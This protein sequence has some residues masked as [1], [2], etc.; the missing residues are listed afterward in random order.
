MGSCL[1]PTLANA[2][3]RHYE[4]LWLNNFPPQFRTV[5]YRIYVDNMFVLFKP[6]DNL[7]S[8]ARHI[9]TRHKYLE[10]K[11]LILNKII[12]FPF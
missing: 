4:K 1:G 7:L 5:I 3:L 9:N 8:F 2:F 10:F 6:K 11:Y 12:A